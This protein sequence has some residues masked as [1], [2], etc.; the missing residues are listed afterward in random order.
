[1][2]RNVTI[3]RAGDEALVPFEFFHRSAN[4]DE[5]ESWHNAEFFA[6]SRISAQLGRAVVELFRSDYS[7]LF[8]SARERIAAGYEGTAPGV[9]S[10]TS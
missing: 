6:F 8:H 2:I 3:T 5:F 1:M 7:E 9:K 10:S 4:S